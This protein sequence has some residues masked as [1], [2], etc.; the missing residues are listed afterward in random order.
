MKTFLV[1]VE[2]EDGTWVG[3]PEVVEGYAQDAR[4]VAVRKAEGTVPE[5]V[6]TVHELLPVSTHIGTMI[7]E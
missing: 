2:A 6:V 5:L 7:N 4:E 3:D 1:A